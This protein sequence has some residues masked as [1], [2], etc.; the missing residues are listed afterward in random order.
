MS[1]FPRTRDALTSL[2][3]H[4]NCEPATMA[5]PVGWVDELE[6]LESAVGEAFAADTADR[7]DPKVAREF[8]A[9][10]GNHEWL[11]RLCAQE[12]EEAE[13]DQLMLP[14]CACGRRPYACD[15]SR[16]GCAS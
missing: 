10:P 4:H 16:N 13:V 14:F 8:G 15:G 7:N 9:C 2:A 11:R 3:L 12:V 5:D 1:H 6:R